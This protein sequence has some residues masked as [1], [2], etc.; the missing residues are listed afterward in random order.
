MMSSTSR[1]MNVRLRRSW[2]FALLWVSGCY[3]VSK[4]QSGLSTDLSKSHQTVTESVERAYHPSLTMAAEHTI[5]VAKDDLLDCE[6]PRRS[7]QS[8][9][10][11]LLLNPQR[12]ISSSHKIQRLK[13][14][15]TWLQTQRVEF[16]IE[17]DQYP[18]TVQTL[19]GYRESLDLMLTRLGWSLGRAPLRAWYTSQVLERSSNEESQDVI[20]DAQGL[21]WGWLPIHHLKPSKNVSVL[22]EEMSAKSDDTAQRCKA[23]LSQLYPESGSTSKPHPLSLVAQSWLSPGLRLLKAPR[24]PISRTCIRLF[25]LDQQSLKVDQSNLGQDASRWHIV[26]REL[27]ARPE[28][29]KEMTT[30]GVR[31][32]TL[33]LPTSPHL[34]P[35]DWNHQTLKK[36]WEKRELWWGAQGCWHTVSQDVI[37][38]PL[39]GIKTRWVD[40][41]PKY[42]TT[43]TLSV[44]RWRNP[45]EVI[46]QLTSRVG[47]E[48]ENLHQVDVSVRGVIA[49]LI[50]PQQ[51]VR[52]RANAPSIAALWSRG[53]A[54]AFVL[55]GITSIPIYEALAQLSS[56]PVIHK[57]AL[58][59]N[60]SVGPF[61]YLPRD[62]SI[63]PPDWSRSAQNL[64]QIAQRSQQ[65]FRDGDLI[66]LEATMTDAR[67]LLGSPSQFPTDQRGLLKERL[68]RFLRTFTTDQG[69]ALNAGGTISFEGGPWLGEQHHR[70]TAPLTHLP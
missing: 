43:S 38:A 56:D 34:L 47:L 26:L 15:S 2:I 60:S 3:P 54:R 67:H 63:P 42:Q 11:T 59:S 41:I 37:Q 12:L 29:T 70:V 35:L 65:K 49:A 21:S 45:Q 61:I 19:R 18:D 53:A 4:R 40:L 69:R 30:N 46:P 36:L 24:P 52:L 9:P 8:I 50:P 68:S 58:S 57:L 31:Y 64:L 55:A 1:L 32:L 62:S 44:E 66:T 25:D 17:L 22:S 33:P 7:A 6:P 39:S 28:K 27:S 51:T 10:F 23:L 48:W 16:A 5:V 20:S 13:H 14:W